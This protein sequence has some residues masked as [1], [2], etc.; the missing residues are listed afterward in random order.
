MRSQGC[1]GNQPLPVMVCV[2]Q[3]SGHH[4][5]MNT[6]FLLASVL[7]PITEPP[8]PPAT[9][10]AMT[11]DALEVRALGLAG[12]SAFDLPASA[13]VV[14]VGQ[15]AGQ[16][17]VDLT[18][19]FDRIPGVLARDRQN[20][21]Q[22]LQLSIRGYGA[23]STFGVRGIRVLADGLPA[24]APDGQAQLTQFN[25]L[26]IERIEVVRGPFAALHGNA[27]GGVV[28]LLS[29][30]GQ[31]GD[32]WWL[33]VQAGSDG[34]AMLGARLQGGDAGFGY[35]VVPMHW[36]S[37][38]ARGHSAA[39][40]SS[41]SGRFDWSL[42]G[43]GN[44]AMFVQHFHAPDAQ[45]PR[46]LTAAEWRA[47]PRL[48]APVART[49][50]TR[51][52]VAQQQLGLVLEQPWQAS[53]LRIAAHAGQ[54]E[55]LQFLAIP[56]IAQANPLHGGGVVDLDSD[57]AGLDLRL[58]GQPHPHWQWSAGINSEGQ[59]QHRRGWENFIGPQLGVRGRLR[60]DQMD[61]V[62]NLDGH[63][64]LAWQPAPRWQ[65]Q[66][67]LRHSRV[68]FHS[69]DRY[70]RGANPDDSGRTAY[71]RTTP[72]AGVS[73]SPAP[74][75]RWHVALGR[76]LETP[77]FNELAYRADGAPGL[78]LDLRA[79]RSRQWESGLRWQGTGKA[80]AGVTVFS[81]DTDDEL[82]VLGS[83]GG[84]S[85]YGNIGSTA[86]QGWELEAQW[87]LRQDLQAHLAWTRLDARITGCAPAGC[88]QWQRHKRLPGTARDALQVQVQGQHQGWQWQL[89]ATGLSAM[90]ADDA[91]RALAPRHVLFDAGLQRQW[92]TAAGP[93][94]VSLALDNL[95]D[96]AHVASVV[97]N[98]GN[99]R[100]YEPG[101]G[102]TLR[103]SLRWQFSPVSGVP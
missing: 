37:D 59:R 21:A 94:Q 92:P 9:S 2:A 74:A 93:L 84:R 7:L 89:G 47:D 98:D 64:Q 76:G 70:I 14:Q 18:A 68:Q 72:V 1:S 73:F 90:P 66:A 41:V 61:T 80:R 42:P 51:K 16:G 97:V 81:A 57:Y 96:R 3:R 15:H 103:L 11:L 46:A 65:L 45:D 54:R 34:E 85:V 33:Q 26:G 29:R 69:D 20:R 56:A 27:S 77:T 79:A 38:G 78:A 58:S 55:V 50:N 102:R 36:R 31:A 88:G 86:R 99:G 28:Q 83:S 13:S 60:R 6:A 49:F 53:Q 82:G 10:P 87:P 43:S 35:S 39:Q 25:L 17:A 44:L 30:A 23:R 101:A 22:D 75:W 91:N 48:A 4:V 62:W 52:S 8:P 19:A 95:T 67:G 40:R 12:R 100:Y 24:G 5:G 71:H 63:A 32:P